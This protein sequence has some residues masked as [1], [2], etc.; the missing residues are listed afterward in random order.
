MGIFSKKQTDT[1]QRRSADSIDSPKPSSDISNRFFNKNANLS[2]Y[3]RLEQDQSPRLQHHQL[4]LKRRNLLVVLL[5][6]TL[7]IIGLF[8][9]ISQLTAT[10]SIKVSS[11]ISQPIELNRYQTEVQKYLQANPFNRLK[12][13]LDEQK[14]NDYIGRNLSEVESVVQ[15]RTVGLGITEF[16]VSFREPVA[17]WKIDDALYYVD[18]NGVAF[19]V[20]LYTEPSVKVI[21]NSGAKVEAGSANISKRFLG[22]VG[23]VVSLSEGMGYQVSEAVLPESTTRQFNV[24][25]VEPNLL[26]KMTIDRSVADQ[27]GDM[28]RAVDHMISSNTMPAYIDVRVDDKV[29]FK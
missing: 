10:V 16:V 5:M 29:F 22:F 8:V 23:R 6:V 12:F 27:V 26:V 20:N 13:V 11:D 14:L 18:K 3:R 7:I 25:L 1:P 24:K 4:S 17:S 9:L 15:G 28:S 2:G 19:A 21:D